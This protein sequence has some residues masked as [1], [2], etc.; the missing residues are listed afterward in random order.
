VLDTNSNGMVIK[1]RYLIHNR[2]RSTREPVYETLD[3]I[4]KEHEGL[5]NASNLSQKER[6]EEGSEGL[7]V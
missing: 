4:L 7:T 1:H 6:D 3:R 2:R 5:V